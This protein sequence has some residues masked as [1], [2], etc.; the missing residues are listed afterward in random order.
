MLTSIDVSGTQYI[1]ILYVFLH[2]FLHISSVNSVYFQMS[3]TKISRYCNINIALS[4]HSGKHVK[5][6][7]PGRV[8]LLCLLTHVCILTVKLTGFTLGKGG[9]SET[10]MWPYSIVR[11]ECCPC[12]YFFGY[13]LH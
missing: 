8:Y 9:L 5:A 11:W 13:L 3:E 10:S 6:V 1:D 2:R 4:G 12:L 7:F